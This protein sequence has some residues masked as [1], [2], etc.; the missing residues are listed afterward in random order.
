[1]REA[2]RLLVSGDPETWGTI[3]RSLEFSFFAT[4]FS[5]FPGVAFGVWMA[6][7]DTRLRRMALAVTGALTAL[8]TVVIGLAV[9]ALISRTG[10][11]GSLGWLFAPQGIVLGEALLA[12]PLVANLVWSG[13]ARLDVRFFE[14]LETLGIRGPHR[15]A[16]VLRE[17]AS[18]MAGAFV[19]AFGRVTGEVG[20]AMLLGGNIRFVTRTMTTS[21]ALDTSTGEFGRAAAFGIALF[22]IA[23]A[24]NF[25]VHA[26][27]P[28]ER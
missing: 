4:L 18:V 19:S 17:G 6:G 27:R 28:H 3:A 22:S 5:L 14:T 8:P 7:K 21:I 20:V 25:A 9:Y 1:M 16:A 24:V 26:L 11:L 15:F 23:L 12:F 13:L 2:L 10:P